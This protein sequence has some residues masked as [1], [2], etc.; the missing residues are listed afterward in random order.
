MKTNETQTIRLIR[1][2]NDLVLTIVDVRG[3]REKYC[4]VVLPPEIAQS[5]ERMISDCG[6]AC[7]LAHGNK[8]DH[9]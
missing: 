1:D 9:A 8:N 4:S 6:T 5:L 2:G 3:Q 7:D